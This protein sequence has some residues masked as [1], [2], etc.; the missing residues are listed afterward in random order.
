ME[1]DGKVY[2]RFGRNSICAVLD[3]EKL[4]T[5]VPKYPVLKRKFLSF[6]SKTIIDD[7][8]HPL[9]YIMSL[10]KHLKRPGMADEEVLKAWKL[11][12][13]LKNVVIKMLTKIRAVKAK[14]SLRDMIM[15]YL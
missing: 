5:I 3:Y 4:M 14:P 13:T 9:D 6:K 15:V 12:N 8:V 2:Y 10:P 1:D 7:K 11:E